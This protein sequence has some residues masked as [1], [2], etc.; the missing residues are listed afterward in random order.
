MTKMNVVGWF[1]LYVID[2]K[3]AAGFY[4]N[5]LKLKLEEIVDPTG[6]T[7]MMSFPANMSTY[8]ASGALVK[9]NH[10]QPG[11]GGSLLYFNV[12]DCS[13][14]ESLTSKLGGRVIRSKFSIGKFGWITICQD[15]EGNLIGF[16]SLK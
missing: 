5:I 11:S 10:S 15:T 2:M 16:N 8:G 12:D 7:Q 6:E 3:R 1:D 14:Q 9:S 13:E 4:E